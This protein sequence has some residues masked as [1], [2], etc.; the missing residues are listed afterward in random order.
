MRRGGIPGRGGRHRKG[1]SSRVP[2]AGLGIVV[3]ISTAVAACMPPEANEPHARGAF[4]DVYLDE[5]LEL[6][7]GQLDSYD[8]FLLRIFESYAGTQPGDF[9]ASVH[10]VR[11]VENTPCGDYL[12]CADHGIAWITQDLGQYH[13]L[14]HLMQ[15]YLDGRSIPSLEE[16]TAEAFGP[17]AELAYAVEQLGTFDAEFLFAEELTATQYGRA[18]VFSRF[19]LERAGSARY[20]DFFRAMKD[21]RETGEEVFREEFLDAFDED[22]GTVWGEFVAA[23]RCAYDYWFC[24]QP[25]PVRELPLEVSGVDCED[26]DTLGFSDPRA[27]KTRGA[28][29]AEKV[30]R[31]NLGQDG[32]VTFEL[33][34]SDAYLGRCGTCTNQVPVTLLASFDTPGMPPLPFDVDLPAG[35]YVLILRDGGAGD[36]LIRAYVAD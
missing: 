23:P 19:L 32:P 9:R 10:A 16:G 18:A 4:V 26:P 35:E 11:S 1:P 25:A 31:F 33:A 13:E 21:A 8:D 7:G 20:R 36:A 15:G 12:S 30:I 22:F 6:C 5:G 34:H 29:R 27:E 17:L 2:L 3:V 28:F 14:V 24:G